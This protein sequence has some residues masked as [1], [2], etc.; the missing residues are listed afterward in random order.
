MQVV[1]S[2]DA[3]RE[4]V[5]QWRLAGDSIV[6]VPTM[7]N[8]HQGHLAL[9]KA[10]QKKADRVIVSVFVNPTQFV[11]GDGFAAYPRTPEQD[12]ASLQRINT[13]LMFLPQEETVYPSGSN[14][15]VTVRGLS[16]LYCGA[17]RVGHFSGVATIV[18]KLFNI[19]QPDIAV[20]GEK[21]WQQLV[22]IRRMV[23]DLNIP[24]Q[25]Y[26]VATVR[27]TDGLAMSSRNSFLTKTERAVAAN[28]YQSLCS[29]RNLLMAGG[30]DFKRIEL[31]QIEFLQKV[32]FAPDYFSICHAP[33]LQPATEFDHELAI[34]T[35]ARLGKAR[36]IDNIQ[37][38]LPQ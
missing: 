36:L 17:A 21:D 8:L 14:T 29:A 25:I 13:D 9:V 28:L 5:R 2:I 37:V 22:I 26:G 12:K 20:F 15:E 35:A 4:R 34:L 31:Q 33:D 6:L 27:E 30:K 7:G 32:G 38:L 1:K 10:A 23:R 19:V 16:D 24:V 11:V 3:L 18:C